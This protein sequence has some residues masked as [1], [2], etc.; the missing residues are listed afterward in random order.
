[1]AGLTYADVAR[2]PTPDVFSAMW[3]F[4]HAFAHHHQHLVLP[5]SAGLLRPDIS[6]L[7]FEVL[8]GWN[9]AAG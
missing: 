5:A 2:R 9:T 6:P 1:M 3:K 8:P 4:R 7:A